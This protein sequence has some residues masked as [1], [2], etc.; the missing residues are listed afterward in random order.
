MLERLPGKG[1]APIP[2]RPWRGAACGR[3][4]TPSG[5]A[6]L[7]VSDGRRWVAGGR[8]VGWRGGARWVAVDVLGGEGGEWRWEAKMALSSGGKSVPLSL[9]TSSSCSPRR[10]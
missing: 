6:A 10:M 4:W 3:V 7:G 9:L 1:G 2:D 8:R 5:A